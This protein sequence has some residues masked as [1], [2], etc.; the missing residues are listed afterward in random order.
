MLKVI[1]INT[2]SLG[3]LDKLWGV[4][5]KVAQK[6]IDYREAHGGFKTPEEIKLV[7]GITDKTWDMWGSKGWE[8]KVK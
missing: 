7:D 3:E 1:N 5:K 8:I 6:I 4:G 2:A